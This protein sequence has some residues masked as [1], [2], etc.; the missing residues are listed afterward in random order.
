MDEQA[1]EPTRLPIEIETEDPFIQM[2]MGIQLGVRQAL[3]IATGIFL[4][5]ILLKLTTSFLPLSTFFAGLLW[6]PVAIGGL[7]MALVRRD[8]V[9]LEEYLTRRIIFMIS[10]RNFILRERSRT[11]QAEEAE[12]RAISE[13]DEDEGSADWG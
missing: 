5:W 11:L 9:Y 4:W 13:R 12:W 8:G 10:E 7:V 1:P 2:P 6:A 3:T